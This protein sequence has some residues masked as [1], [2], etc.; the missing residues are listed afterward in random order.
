MST[1]QRVVLG[2]WLAMVALA[3]VRGIRS[4]GNLPQ[5]SV[6]I[7]SGVLFS[8]LLAIAGVGPLGSLAATLA[9]GVDVGAVMAP[10]LQ[11]RTTGPLNDIAGFLNGLAG[12]QG[13]GSPELRI[14]A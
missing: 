13:G 14:A 7:G 8:I 2:A 4:A 5:P 12:A 10:Y 1:S 3:T 6:Y 9:V 11:G